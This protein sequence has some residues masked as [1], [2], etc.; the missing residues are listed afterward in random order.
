MLLE[1]QI[2]ISEW[3]LKD[4]VALKTGVMDVKNNNNK[5]NKSPL[6]LQE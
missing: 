4:H 3:S 2:S 5:K 6:P 1:Y